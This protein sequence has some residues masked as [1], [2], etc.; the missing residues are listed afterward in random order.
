MAD[1]DACAMPK[2]PVK[3]TCF[4]THCADCLVSLNLMIVAISYWTQAGVALMV[5]LA[6]VRFAK[7]SE[8]ELSSVSC[9]EKILGCFCKT[10]PLT[11]RII[12]LIG[13]FQIA[14]L[15]IQAFVGPKALAA[16]ACI[17]SQGPELGVTVI[18]I[19][20]VFNII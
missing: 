7:K 12:T 6:F 10:L 2:P 20:T 3:E 16:T 19:A 15:A 11:V 18:V 14:L 9:F 17:Y 8:D 1:K 5:F 4:C 13:F